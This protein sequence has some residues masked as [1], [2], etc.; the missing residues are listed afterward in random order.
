MG[1]GV[2]IGPA[3]L[4]A[5]VPQ[6]ATEIPETLGY[7]AHNP[8]ETAEKAPEAVANR[9]VRAV[10]QA[11]QNPAKTAGMLLGSAAA[12]GGVFR[13]TQGTKLGAAARYSLQPGRNS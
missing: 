7:T 9:A 10:E 5:Q 3:G 6:L 4:V 13:A 2:V 12:S 11:R 1:E 8:L